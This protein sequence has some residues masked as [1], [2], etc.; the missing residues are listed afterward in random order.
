MFQPRHVH[1]IFLVKG[2]ARNFIEADHVIWAD[3]SALTGIIERHQYN[4]MKPSLGRVD[5]ERNFF[6]AQ[7]AG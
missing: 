3:Q 7:Y 6:W 4:A 2:D 5:E 1:A